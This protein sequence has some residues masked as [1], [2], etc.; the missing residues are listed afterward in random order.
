M[1]L[2]SISPIFFTKGLH[3]ILH[4]SVTEI[5]QELQSIVEKQGE[6]ALEFAHLVKENEEVLVAIQVGTTCI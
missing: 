1:I 6:N 5:E 3:A 4:I 2:C